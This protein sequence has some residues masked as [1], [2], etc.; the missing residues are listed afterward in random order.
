MLL[1]IKTILSER[2]GISSMNTITRWKR[3]ADESLASLSKNFH[4]KFHHHV[5]FFHTQNTSFF[6]FWWSSFWHVPMTHK[7]ILFIPHRKYLWTSC[8]LNGLFEHETETS[9]CSNT[10]RLTT[11]LVS[12]IVLKSELIIGVVFYLFRKHRLGLSTQNFTWDTKPLQN[13][14]YGHHLLSS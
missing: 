11:Q 10:K 12:T 3:I 5:D 6:I 1:S 2:I 14:A 4:I 7:N 13:V 8:G 9:K